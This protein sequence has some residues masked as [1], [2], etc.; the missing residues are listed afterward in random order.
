MSCQGW[1]RLRDK[2]RFGIA[3]SSCSHRPQGE[4]GPGVAKM[5]IYM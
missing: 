2:T 5:S 4:E 1:G 3:Q